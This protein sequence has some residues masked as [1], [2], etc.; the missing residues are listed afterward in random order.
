MGRLAAW[1]YRLRY[2]LSAVVV[3]GFV[4]LA[5]KANFTEID[6]DLTMWVAKTDPV[7]VTYERFRDEFGGTRTLIVAIEAPSKAALV[8]AD[9]PEVRK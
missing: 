3:L 6:N 5:P 9:G 4:A 8:S 1:L 2:P 7:Y